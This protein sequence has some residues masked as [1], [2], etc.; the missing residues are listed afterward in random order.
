M[1]RIFTFGLEEEVV[2]GEPAMEGAG[3]GDD[4]EF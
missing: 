2:Q 4:L 1:R 3:R